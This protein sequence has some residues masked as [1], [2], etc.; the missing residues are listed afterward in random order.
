[1]PPGCDP[2]HMSL[3]SLNLGNECRRIFICQSCLLQDRSQGWLHRGLPW[4]PSRPQQTENMTSIFPNPNRSTVVCTLSKVPRE[5]RTR[6]GCRGGPCTYLRQAWY[7][8][9]FLYFGHTLVISC[10]RTVLPTLP[11]K[12]GS[13]MD[14]GVVSLEEVR[15][16]EKGDVEKATP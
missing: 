4:D 3:W 14:T 15:D 2:C 16:R 8:A 12:G 7:Q 10:L 9:L 6:A 5:D 1:M 13:E 11:Q